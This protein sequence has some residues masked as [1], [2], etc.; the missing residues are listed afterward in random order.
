MDSSEDEDYTS[1]LSDVKVKIETL[2]NDSDADEKFNLVKNDEI[3]QEGFIEFVEIKNEVV[4]DEDDPLFGEIKPIR[5]KKGKDGKKRKPRI[6][7]TL[8]NEYFGPGLSSSSLF[9]KLGGFFHCPYCVRRFKAKGGLKKHLTLHDTT[10]FNFPCTHCE[11]EAFKTKAELHTHL[12]K[13]HDVKKYECSQCREAFISK[14]RLTMHVKDNHIDKDATLFECPIC[15]VYYDALSSMT[16]HMTRMHTKN[17]VCLICSVEFNDRRDLIAHMKVHPKEPDDPITEEMGDVRLRKC[18]ICRRIFETRSSLNFHMKKVH[19]NIYQCAHCNRRYINYKAMKVHIMNHKSDR[20]LYRCDSCGK[21]YHFAASLENHKTNGS[22]QPNPC[23]CRICNKVFMN[24][25][26][27]RK[28]ERV[29]HQM[30]R[31]KSVSRKLGPKC[32]CPHC[33][34]SFVNKY[35]LNTHLPLH[36]DAKNFKCD[37]CEKAFKAQNSLRYHL[38]NIHF[39]CVS[40]NNSP[41][42]SICQRKFNNKYTLNMH[43]IYKHK[44]PVDGSSKQGQDYKQKTEQALQQVVVVEE[45]VELVEVHEENNWLCGTQENPMAAVYGVDEKQEQNGQNLHFQQL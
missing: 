23:L 27:K 22:C 34:K 41:T 18:K 26:Y 15:W 4:N 13:K 33:G 38:A 36:G 35:S 3:K 28:H 39:K 14:Y 45:K 6:P 2:E 7:P 37:F 21:T 44:M 31:K 5:S 25:E 24:P 19:Y 9:T 17:P 20:Y 40:D 16:L 43:L 8:V 32:I 10:T 30:D 29:F 12:A 11:N 1:F 42:C